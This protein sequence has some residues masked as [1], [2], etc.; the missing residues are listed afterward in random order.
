MTPFEPQS[1]IGVGTGIYTL[2]DISYILHLPTGK[3]RK[4][5]HEYWQ[6]RFSSSAESGFSHGSGKEL[7]TNFLTL[8]EFFTFYQLRQEGVSAQKIVKA[9]QILAKTFRTKY[10]FAKSSLLTDGERVLFNGDAGN[11]IQADETL[12]INIKEAIEPFCKKVEFN[13]DDMVKR[14]YPLGKDHSIVIDPKRQFG[15]PVIGD[16]NI[17]AE[18]IYNLHRGGESIDTIS[19]LYSLTVGQVN[20][21]INYYRRAA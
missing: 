7:V 6:L 11:I 19:S 8:I 13:D 3:V 15:Q 1:L 2:P 5:M 18:T 17:L 12:Q 4:W 9:H 10:P 20:D 21:V 14:F 16:T